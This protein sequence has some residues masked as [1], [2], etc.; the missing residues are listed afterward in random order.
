MSDTAI[1]HNLHGW[2]FVQV[3]RDSAANGQAAAKDRCGVKQGRSCERTQR[4]RGSSRFHGA[5]RA[6]H[7]IG[8]PAGGPGDAR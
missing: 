5:D 3:M 7:V 6:M 2:A 4:A 8:R 1:S